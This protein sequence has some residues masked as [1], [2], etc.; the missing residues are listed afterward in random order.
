MERDQLY[1][2]K[3]YRGSQEFYRFVPKEVPPQKVFFLRDHP[4]N[5]DVSILQCTISAA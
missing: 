3:W 1:A 4:I 2:V 5:I